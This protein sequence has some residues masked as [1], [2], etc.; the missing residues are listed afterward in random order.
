MSPFAR[1]REGGWWLST[2]RLQVDPWWA[3]EKTLPIQPICRTAQLHEAS[4]N[5]VLAIQSLHGVR[6]Q[7]RKPLVDH[8]QCISPR[9]PKCSRGHSD[10]AP[11]SETSQLHWEWGPLMSH[12]LVL[13]RSS[14][15]L[16]QPVHDPHHAD[17][18]TLGILS[19]L[20]WRLSAQQMV[21]LGS[22]TL[23][24]DLP[25]ALQI[26]HPNA[27]V[28][29]SAFIFKS[30]GDDG[31]DEL[32]T[33]WTRSFTIPHPNFARALLLSTVALPRCRKR[34]T[35]CV[36]GRPRACH[37]ITR[38]TCPQVSLSFA[39]QR[40][41]WMPK[42]KSRSMRVSL[43]ALLCL[44]NLVPGPSAIFP[45]IRRGASV[46]GSYERQQPLQARHAVQLLKETAH[47]PP[48]R[49]WRATAPRSRKNSRDCSACHLVRPK[50]RWRGGCSTWR[51][52]MTSL[53][54][55]HVA[56]VL[57]TPEW[58]EQRGPTMS[59]TVILLWWH[60]RAHTSVPSAPHACTQLK[61]SAP[62]WR[63][64]RTLRC[65]LTGT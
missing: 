51:M 1:L 9:C 8:M 35:S 26:W 16:H 38:T 47:T 32:S 53:E 31:A 57:E 54:L 46:H 5:F 18:V 50:V 19:R 36:E 45:H 11:Q 12:P 21:A 63:P 27:C 30:L 48:R 24:K 13:T 33:C 6:C 62:R 44:M 3:P 10:R 64:K 34:L 22:S 55:S 14:E 60:W 7:L 39:A 29:Q 15:F 28:P 17:V 23:Q 61:R 40:E 58:T 56:T 4:T 2:S 42:Q 41:S 25:R 43:F 37:P 59:P 52:R 65:H 20:A 49:R